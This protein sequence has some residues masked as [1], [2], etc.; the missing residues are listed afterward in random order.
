MFPIHLAHPSNSVS[1]ERDP[2]PDT[3]SKMFSPLVELSSKTPSRTL[4]NAVGKTLVTTK[5]DYMTLFILFSNAI[6]TDA[7]EKA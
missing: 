1:A 7:G 4:E 3:R 2:N 6:G 5:D